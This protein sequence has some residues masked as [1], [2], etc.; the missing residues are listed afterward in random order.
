MIICVNG[1][2][3]VVERCCKCTVT[4]TVLSAAVNDLYDGLRFAYEPAMAV[5]LLVVRRGKDE[6]L[7]FCLCCQYGLAIGLMC[8]SGV[9]SA[10]RYF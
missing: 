3:L 8:Q 5:D 10:F 7:L 2:T 6:G 9:S 4:A 1:I